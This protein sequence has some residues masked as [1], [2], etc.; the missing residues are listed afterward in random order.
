MK[1]VQALMFD[2]KLSMQDALQCYWDYALVPSKKN[3]FPGAPPDKVRSGEVNADSYKAQ[4]IALEQFVDMHMVPEAKSLA[5]LQEEA[6]EC[7]ARF[8]IA[9]LGWSRDLKG[10]VTTLVTNGV[11]VGATD[12]SYV[13]YTK[14][15]EFL[16]GNTKNYPQLKGVQV[17]WAEFEEALR[18]QDIDLTN[19]VGLYGGQFF[20]N[21]PV[22]KKDSMLRVLGQFLGRPAF[23]GRLV[24]R[25]YIL[26]PLGEDN[27]ADRVEWR[28]TIPYKQVELQR[29]LEKGLGRKVTMDVLGKHDYWHQKYTL[30]KITAT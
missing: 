13:A 3:P 10:L 19:V 14:F 26:H 27:P 5:P 11:L 22:R 17:R 23:N 4:N 12:V 1:P 25:L 18:K 24:R 30:F 16:D 15:L 9:G 21:S 29:P 28:N 8:E 6:L 7:K 2:R 20:Q